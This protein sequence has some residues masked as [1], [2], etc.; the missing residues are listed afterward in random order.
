MPLGPFAVAERRDGGDVGVLAGRLVVAQDSAHPRAAAHAGQ[1]EAVELS[2][3]YAIG[4]VDLAHQAVVAGQ[5][6]GRRRGARS[7]S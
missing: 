1:A 2:V 7:R 4:E 6:G 5:Y 3:P